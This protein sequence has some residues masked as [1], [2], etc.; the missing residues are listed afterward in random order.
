M[1]EWLWEPCGGAAGDRAGWG[2][3]DVDINVNNNF[4]R[5]SNINSSRT[6]NRSNTASG[7]WQHNSQHRGGAPYADRSTADRFGGTARRR[8][9]F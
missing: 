3:N 8:L 6:A 4:N 5:N 7:K 1:S 2:H 9:T